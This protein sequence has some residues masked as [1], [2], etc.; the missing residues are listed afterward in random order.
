MTSG[1]NPEDAHY[2]LE[3]LTVGIHEVHRFNKT[4][5]SHAQGLGE[6]ATQ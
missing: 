6:S 5:A 2:S 1:V 3:E 4:C